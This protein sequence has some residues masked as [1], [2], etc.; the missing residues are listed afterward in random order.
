M[1]TPIKKTKRTLKTLMM[2]NSKRALQTSNSYLKTF[3][4]NLSLESP[5][6]KA[7]NTTI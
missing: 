2:N 7:V 3:I 5:M 1:N 6:T 4:T